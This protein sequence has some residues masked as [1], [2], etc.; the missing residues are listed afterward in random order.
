MIEFVVKPS[1]TVQRD[2]VPGQSELEGSNIIVLGN[3][4]NGKLNLQIG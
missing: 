3:G 4:G 1:L 2:F